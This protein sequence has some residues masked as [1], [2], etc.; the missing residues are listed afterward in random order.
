[1]MNPYD[2]VVIGAG[3]GGLTASAALAQKGLKVMLLERHHVPGGCATSFVRGRF[4]FEVALHQLS[5]LGR[6][7]KPGPT[8]FLLDSLGV[9]GD[10]E[11]VE[12]DDLY[13]VVVPGGTDLVLPADLHGTVSVLQDHFP[14]ERDQIEKFFNLM[15]RLSE[16]FMAVAVFRDPQPSRD[17]Y[18]FLYQYSLRSTKEVLDEFFDDELLKAVLSVYWGYLGI[19][20]TRMAFVYLA[21]LFFVF[22]EFKPFH[23]KGGSQAMSNALMNKFVT[24][25]GQARL[26]CGAKQIVVEN[27]EVRGVI[28]D[29]GDRVDTRFVISNASSVLTYLQLIGAENVPSQALVEMRGRSLSA[30]GFVL[31]MG[32]DCQPSDL[33]VSASTSFIMSDPTV[34]DRPT[35]Q[36][37]SLDVDEDLMVLSCYDL[38]DPDFS[39]PGASQMSLVTL[40]FGEP[41]L[42]VPPAEY[43]QVKYRVADGLLRV[44]EKVHPGLR[45][46]IE[47]MEVAT[48]LTHMRYLGHPQGAIYGFE[49]QTK[50]SLFFQPGRR[51]AIQG[52]YFAS[53]WS[54]DCGFQATLEAGRTA[55]NSVIRKI[56]A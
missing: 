34:S 40:K 23:I 29:Q 32:L 53:G 11:F 24:N 37:H 5:G 30:S 36:M 13:R 22:I 28:T 8:R 25:G 19:S 48:P 14:A 31:F 4:E 38:A 16:Q 39:P 21:I 49:Q 35:R 50:D 2:A 47:E 52:L 33:G 9:T 27:G 55:A 18:P 15:Y 12:M 44:A 17:K 42:R 20:P 6:P 54:G 1:M 56:G 51:S 43:F 45:G 41:W 10:L 3:N 46:Y 7:E 26:G